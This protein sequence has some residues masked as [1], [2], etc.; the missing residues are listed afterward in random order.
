[1]RNLPFILSVFGTVAFFVAPA[2]GQ[3][4]QSA[5]ALLDRLLELQQNPAV[6]DAFRAL[7]EERNEVAP[8]ISAATPAFDDPGAAL[9]A[10]RVRGILEARCLECHGPLKQ[11]SGFDL[12]SRD[13][14]L[15]G[16][17]IGVGVISG[18]PGASTLMKMLRHET[19][20]HMPYKEEP[21]APEEI[22]AIAE[23]VRL[24]APYTET[25]HAAAEKA[26]AELAVTDADRTFWSFRPLARAEPPTVS[27]VGWTRNP[28][29]N[30][31]L[32][33]LD[34]NRI[35]PSDEA[36]RRTLIRRVSFD[37]TG[38]PPTPEETAAFELDNRADAY[39]RLVDR[40]LASPQ[41][42]ER[43]GR[44]WL[45][46]ARYADS[47]GY[48]FDAERPTAYHYR[49]FVISAFNEDMPF[50]QFVRWQLAGDEYA[51]DNPA[52][53]AATGFCAAGPNIDNQE[54]ELNFY[55]E[56]DDMAST[57]ASAFLGLT[58]ACARCHD[59][60]YDPIPSR[61][62]YRMLSAFTT[63]K[64]YDVLLTSR[65]ERN[66]Y[67]A[68]KREWDRELGQAK[69]AEGQL[70]E[71][72]R[73]QVRLVKIDA[74]DISD[75]DKAVLKSTGDEDKA[76]RQRLSD[77]FNSQLKVE[78]ED[79]TPLMDAAQI[80]TWETLRAAVAAVEARPP[81]SPQTAL[82][83]TDKKTEPATSYFLA[84]GN[85]D[86]KGEEVT[87]G[88]L[89]VLPGGDAQEFAPA[90]YRREDGET[91]Y[92]RTAL[93][94]WLTDVENGAGRLTARVIVNRLWHHHFGRGI[95]GTP[96][97][98]GMQ[99]DRPTHPELLDWLATELIADGWKLKP[100]HKVIVTSAAY[101]QSS[102][103]DAG[104]DA[105]DPNNL[106]L[107]R[108]EPLRLEAEAIRDSMLAVS[109]CLNATMFGPPIHP[110]MHP[111]AI[112]TGSTN[113]WPKDVVDGPE[114]WRRSV[115]INIRRSVLMPMM[116]SFDAP[117]ATA[118]CSRRNNTTVPTQSLA[119]MNSEFVSDQSVRFA[120]R[121]MADAGEEIRNQVA[122]AYTLALARPASRLEIERGEAFLREQTEARGEYEIALA[123]FCQ[124]LLSLN[125]FVYVN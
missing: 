105:V 14:L 35:A 2:F 87:L 89:Q 96:N 100:I 51:P 17:E 77:A 94:E 61:D 73:R 82:A 23:W 92:Q 5:D 31:V 19:D 24:G 18:D 27:N 122:H 113:K 1:M 119:M 47:A 115:Y 93:A 59:H 42:G 97:D 124:V 83:I 16:G 46:V 53:L 54:T 41:Y 107:W 65:E 43:W 48:E 106:Y 60:K 102:A 28:V 114:T 103:H 20:P 36:D 88:F 6:V 76:E 39:E 123:D 4:S 12:S 52:A 99:G 74:L 32:A 15:K 90:R 21:L 45:D 112:A 91:T 64:R 104:K 118:S 79:L 66:A 34:E 57:T 109:G 58:M 116:Q 67:L 63:T 44:H 55:D 78:R 11:R 125:E 40:L 38:L 10:T 95:V 33:K 117:D 85:P 86:L 75:R 81:K 121:V 80:Q 13:L 120:E 98:F 111:D 70:L 101:R 71:P 29:D 50:D 22:A 108:R 7:V 69:R 110:F 3:D 37:L 26:G 49:D 84:R 8:E 9:F 68:K 72:F 56:L 30:F 25:L 62:Y